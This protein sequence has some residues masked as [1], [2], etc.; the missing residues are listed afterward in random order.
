MSLLKV[1]TVLAVGFALGWGAHA[2]F[3]PAVSLHDSDV[4]LR[5]SSE[6]LG[7]GE[8]EDS[9]HFPQV[10][11]PSHDDIPSL[12][13]MDQPAQALEVS[14]SALE[15]FVVMLEDGRFS[16]AMD[17]IRQA[18]RNSRS[19]F[20]AMKQHTIGFL[21]RL[22]DV[23]RQDEF[24]DLTDLYLSQ[25]FEDIDVLLLLAQFNQNTAYYV[26]AVSV[27]QLAKEYAYQGKPQEQVRLAFRD[28]LQ[29]TD[30]L[31]SA[32]GDF[33]SLGQ[34]Y[35]QADIVGM[36]S[37]VQRYREAE[38]FIELGDPYQAS[39]VLE[40]LVNDR[41]VGDEASK[42][43]AKLRGQTETSQDQVTGQ[44]YEFTSAIDLDRRSN[45]FVV[46]TSFGRGAST[47]LLLDTG[48]SITT[49]A[50]SSFERV[51]H[52]HNFQ[53]VGVR[54]FSTANGM[55]KGQVF[56]VDQFLLGDHVLA[57][58]HIAVLEFEMEGGVD[59]LLGMNVL[60]RF[61]FQIDQDRN[62]LLLRTR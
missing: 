35:L 50:R 24:V 7:A 23:D 25:Y 4:S 33:Y 19:D 61:V 37:P 10:E 39:D 27:F 16:E 15:I 60:G 43:L 41:D 44:S 29:K 48:A 26:E 17:V 51:R 13:T 38:I 47:H 34:V 3:S 8:R 57:D 5:S 21:K 31:L 18:E 52:H 30:K 59:G 58:V 36:L 14:L 62:Q 6:R 46:T 54:M 20:I 55:T 9:T 28:F 11:S 40:T 45:Q 12:V 49:I 56:R 22:L 1:T 2:W 53:E 32:S 42:V